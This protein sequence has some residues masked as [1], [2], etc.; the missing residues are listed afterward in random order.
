[1]IKHKRIKIV[2]SVVLLS[3]MP[4]PVFAIDNDGQNS[5]RERK[6]NEVGVPH[7][8]LQYVRCVQGKE[9]G[10]NKFRDNFDGTIIDKATG[11]MWTQGDSLRGLDWQDALAWAEIKNAEN[12][13]G[14]RDW[15]LPNVKERQSIVNY[16]GVY[17]AI[18]SRYFTI[19][20]ED[21]YF[22]TSTSAYFAPQSPEH[23]YAWYVAFGYA[24]DAS[25]E[26]LHG[27]GAVRFD[28]KAMS[29]PAGEDP[30]R[31]YNYVRLVRDAGMHGR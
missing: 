4:A 6:P 8:G 24:V 28:T 26:D 14:Y 5:F 29:G 17:P 30:E 20:N 13:L 21:A 1:M 22:W 10:R 19:T 2:V 7:Q 3:L 27:A 15:R 31:V 23:Y 16:S 12:Y 9:Y 18:D 11:L 25:G